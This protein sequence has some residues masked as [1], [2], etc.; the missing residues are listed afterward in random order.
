MTVNELRG[1]KFIRQVLPK[2][3][4]PGRCCGAGA[5]LRLEV[6]GGVDLVTGPLAVAAGADVWWRDLR[7]RPSGGPAE[8]VRA[9]REAVR[10][11]PG[12]PACGR[13]RNAQPWPP[14]SPSGRSR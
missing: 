10:R 14:T 6:D 9:L 8:G 7:V 13:R 11:G 12:A 3:T 1:Q 4:R 2:L 5:G